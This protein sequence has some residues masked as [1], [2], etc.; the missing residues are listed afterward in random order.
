LDK[1]TKVSV[2]QLETGRFRRSCLPDE[3]RLY[4]YHVSDVPGETRLIR[5]TGN[6]PGIMEFGGKWQ[7]CGTV[8]FRVSWRFL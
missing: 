5:C 6:L 8:T 7:T 4:F 1:I 2:L 3:L